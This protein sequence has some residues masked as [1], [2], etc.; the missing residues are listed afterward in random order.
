MQRLQAINA[1]APEISSDVIII[2][3]GI[4]GLATAKELNKLGVTNITVID[5]VD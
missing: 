2:G 3:A 5:K 4:T 1:H